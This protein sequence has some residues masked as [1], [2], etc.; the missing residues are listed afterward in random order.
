MGFA[1]G[2]GITWESHGM[3]RMMPQSI[4]YVNAIVVSRAKHTVDLTTPTRG[5][6]YNVR[7][8]RVH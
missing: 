3:S 8:L 4:K 2:P 6:Q 1:M 7:W 5:S